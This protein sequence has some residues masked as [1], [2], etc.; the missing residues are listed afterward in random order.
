MIKAIQKTNKQTNKNKNEIPKIPIDLSE[1]K[2]EKAS[3]P[4]AHDSVT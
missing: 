4:V 2:N 1:K 3:V